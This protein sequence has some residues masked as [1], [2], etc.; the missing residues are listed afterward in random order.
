MTLIP[1]VV[2]EGEY[3]AKIAHRFGFDPDSVWQAK[4]N[5][6]L[7]KEGRTPDLLCS[8]DILYIPP[9]KREWLSVTI[10]SVNKF[11]GKVPVV[12]VHARF[13]TAAQ[14]WANEAYTVEGADLPAGTLDGDG[15]FNAEVPITVSALILLFAK[16]KARFNVR[17]GHLDPISTDS[18]VK[19]R[20]GH[21][22][23]LV[24]RSL[25][26][27]IHE[28]AMHSRAVASFQEAQNLPVTGVADP[29]TC[30]AIVAAHG[31]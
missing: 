16:R 13:A 15:N 4:E 3:L 22:G 20:L 17:V 7:R 31:S 24:R 5:D 11:V 2:Q 18:G 25:S 19:Q 28:D 1:Y 8:G 14:A 30:D 29:K 27:P 23:F 10:G 12:K 9:A 21:L 6:P 26:L